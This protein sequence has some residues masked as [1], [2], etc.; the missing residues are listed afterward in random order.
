MSN[1]AIWL[2]ISASFY[3]SGLAVFAGT[4][5][6]T[7]LAGGAAASVAFVLPLNG[8]AQIGPYEAAWVTA[9]DLV[10]GVP[11]QPALA[12]ILLMHLLS[13]IVCA[14]QAALSALIGIGKK[15]PLDKSA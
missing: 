5:P 4:G 9:V 8:L 7:A 11:Q 2:F 10:A 15:S 1:V 12:T 14:F 6:I 3:L 13:L